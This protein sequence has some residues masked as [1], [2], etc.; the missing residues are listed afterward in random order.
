MSNVQYCTI[1]IYLEKLS[2]Q[3]ALLKTLSISILP[4]V[5]EGSTILTGSKERRSRQDYFCKMV[6]MK[7]KSGRHFPFP[8]QLNE[9]RN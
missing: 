3:F 8:L 7:E 6:A 9:R 1:I 2:I 4:A 5:K